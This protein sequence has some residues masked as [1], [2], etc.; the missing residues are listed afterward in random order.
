M[1]AAAGSGAGRSGP[2]AA[3]SGSD[4]AS[5][6]RR[7]GTGA[8]AEEAVETGREL[9]L[10]LRDHEAAHEE[11]VAQ[12]H[13]HAATTFRDEFGDLLDYRHGDADR[14]PATH[15]EGAAERALV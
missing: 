5:G 6:S 7:H 1:A 14:S 10:L 8:L 12:L 4:A 15:I 9:A 2:G 13:L 3:G 11:R